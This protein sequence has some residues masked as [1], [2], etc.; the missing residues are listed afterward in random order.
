MI[1]F[2]LADDHP[3]VKL[4]LT[5]R[6]R[7][8]F[9]FTH[10]CEPGEKGLRIGKI[11]EQCFLHRRHS[12]M[13]PFMGGR[14]V[15]DALPK[16]KAALICCVLTEEE[17]DSYPK[18]EDMET[19]RL[20]VPGSSTKKPRWSLTTHRRLIILSTSLNLPDID[21]QEDL[22]A[23]NL[24]KTYEKRDFF[25]DWF[26]DHPEI[27]NPGLEDP[28]RMLAELIWGAP[29]IR[30]LLRNITICTKIPQRQPRGS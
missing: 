20:I 14:R 21:E 27:S 6:A 7:K 1:P 4:R 17:Q 8:D 25:L 30:A 15:G 26:R 2:Y 10:R 29:K 3:A 24:K 18:K 16:V 9:I 13:I 22:R 12:S 5:A 19:G 28:T 11:W 23:T